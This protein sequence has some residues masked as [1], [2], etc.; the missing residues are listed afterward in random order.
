LER[1]KLESGIRRI[2][3]DLV[4]RAPFVGWLRLSPRDKRDGSVRAPIGSGV[5]DH[6]VPRF[7]DRER[8]PLGH[9]PIT[10][11]F[12]AHVL[13]PLKR[14]RFAIIDRVYFSKQFVLALR[15]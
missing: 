13:F 3:R 4:D 10:G 14:Q 9:A 5:H 7:R 6:A 12:V 11:K 1:T 2:G 8:Q 15:R